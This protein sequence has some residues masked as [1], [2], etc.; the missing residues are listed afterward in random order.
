MFVCPCTNKLQTSEQQ[1]DRNLKC[2]DQFILLDASEKIKPDTVHHFYTEQ[3]T[4][5][6]LCLNFPSGDKSHKTVPIV[7]QN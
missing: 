3:V 2:V 1:P 5:L 4:S 6:L 7:L